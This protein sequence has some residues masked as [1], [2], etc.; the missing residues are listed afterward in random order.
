[1]PGRHEIQSSFNNTLKTLKDFALL[2]DI[3]IENEEK[4]AE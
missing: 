4:E 2:I 3:I 1:M